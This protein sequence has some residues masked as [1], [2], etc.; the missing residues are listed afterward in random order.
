[1]SQLVNDFLTPQQ[2]EQF[3]DNGFENI[4]P[5]ELTLDHEVLSVVTEVLELVKQHISEQRW[6]V[7]LASRSQ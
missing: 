3:I 1:M 7:E 2:I 5:E 6:K 4:S